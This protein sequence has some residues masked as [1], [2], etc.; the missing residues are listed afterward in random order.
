[1]KLLPPSYTPLYH[2]LALYRVW[3]LERFPGF[4]GLAA[5]LMYYVQRPVYCR[6]R[7]YRIPFVST[8]TKKPS[9]SLYQVHKKVSCD[10]TTKQQTL[11]ESLW[12]LTKILALGFKNFVSNKIP[13][14]VRLHSGICCKDI[15]NNMVAI[16]NP[17]TLGQLFYCI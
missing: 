16:W 3:S 11:L 17:Y 7:Q 15:S 8:L 6:L 1:M 2:F 12:K 4:F 9:A 13:N 14:P 5:T 10:T